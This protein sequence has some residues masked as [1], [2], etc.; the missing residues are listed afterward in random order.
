MYSSENRPPLP[1]RKSDE[2]ISRK[3]LVQKSLEEKKQSPSTSKDVQSAGV[4]KE[5]SVG[6]KAK[7]PGK[8]VTGRPEKSVGLKAKSPDKEVT[9]RP[10]SQSELDDTLKGKGD[11]L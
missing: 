1:H 4:T 5:K 6:L 2:K 9:G 8:E 10:E 11:C 3:A 7:S